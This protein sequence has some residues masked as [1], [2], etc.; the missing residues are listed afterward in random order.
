MKRK[1]EIL[2]QIMHLST[3]SL[4][5]LAAVTLTAS[6]TSGTSVRA[7][8]QQLPFTQHNEKPI[9][10]P[11]AAEGVFS[12]IGTFAHLPYVD[13]LK[14]DSAIY[15]I[16]ILGNIVIRYFTQSYRNFVGKRYMSCVIGFLL[17]SIKYNRCPF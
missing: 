4:V 2:V 15:D 12:G 17:I 8:R 11:T 5:F 14:N 1:K 13:S 6:T 9:G 7:K 16:A 3:S 10:H